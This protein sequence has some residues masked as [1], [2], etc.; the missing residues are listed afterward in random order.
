MRAD[1][2]VRDAEVLRD[3]VA[4]GRTWETLGQSY[5]GFVTM[6]YLSLAPEGLDAC[7][8]HRRPARA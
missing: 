8:V 2:I 3:Q 5:G 7:Y 6:T 1:S 4:G